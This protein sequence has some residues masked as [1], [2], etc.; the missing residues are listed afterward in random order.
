MLEV[1]GDDQTLHDHSV[2]C[3]EKIDKRG[4]RDVVVQAS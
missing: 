4:A 3:G 1:I 2:F